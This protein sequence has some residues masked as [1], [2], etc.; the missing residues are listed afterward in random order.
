MREGTEAAVTGATTVRGTTG[1]PWRA[2]G[3][4]ALAATLLCGLS[5]AYQYRFAPAGTGTGKTAVRILP[6]SDLRQI[7]RAL[8]Q[9]GVVARPELFVWAARL[10]GLER[11]LQAGDY[12]LEPG[13]TLPTLLDALLAGKGRSLMVTIPEGWRLDQIADRLDEARIV[14][15]GAFLAAARRPE[16]LR[17]LGIPGPTAEGFLFPDSYP[18][19]APS[20][21][22]EVIGIMHRQ[23]RKV[24]RE[25][26]LEGPIGTMTPLEVVTLASIVERETAA[27]EERP[28]VAG[29]FLNRLRRGWPLQ[30]D[31]TVIYGVEGFDGNLTRRDLRAPT[32][33][34][35]Y[36][37]RGLPPG[38]IAAPGKESLRAVLHPAPGDFLYFVAR[39]DGTHQFSRTLTEHN[40]AVQRYQLAGVRR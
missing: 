34:N 28:V 9:A 8:Q 1:T 35:T 18:F 6:G 38:P 23:F 40:R 14:D 4:A 16:L 20:S 37:I 27:P 29:V 5:L 31:P 36:V 39:K 13:W 2:V 11:R 33:Y 7:A 10:R 3:A 32:P 22:E 30:S 15:R 25:L 17:Q 24:W 26:E 12:Q 21:A 19:P